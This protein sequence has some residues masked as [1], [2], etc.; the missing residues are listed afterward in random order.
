[1]SIIFKEVLKQ[2]SKTFEKRIEDGDI[3]FKVIASLLRRNNSG[4]YLFYAIT[5]HPTVMRYKAG[6][7][8]KDVRGDLVQELKKKKN[9]IYSADIEYDKLAAMQKFEGHNSSSLWKLYD[10]ML[11]NVVEK[12]GQ[13]TKRDVTL[14]QVEDWWKT[15]KR[16]N[17][18][19]RLIEKE[20]EIV[21]VYLKAK[22]ELEA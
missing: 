20:Q 19:T 3:N 8:D 7:L 9:W 17:K 5:V 1:M 12:L 18:T 22:Q 16:Y 21:E 6:T 15:S 11:G 10:S 4:L 13:K 14:D 2:D